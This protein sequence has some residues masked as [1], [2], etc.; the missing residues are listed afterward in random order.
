MKAVWIA[1]AA[2]ALP[3]AAV[4]VYGMVRTHNTERDPLQREFANGRISTP[5]RPSATEAG[6]GAS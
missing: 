5:E 1:G 2:L 3:I 4:T 6:S